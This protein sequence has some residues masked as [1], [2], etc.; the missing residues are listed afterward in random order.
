MAITTL[1]KPT[2]LESVQDDLWYIASS[3]NSGQTD[4]KFVFDV[5]NNTTGEQLVRVKLYPDPATG[6]GYFNA[7]NVVRNEIKYNWFT[8]TNTTSVDAAPFLSSISPTGNTA[9]VIYDV[10][11]GE[12]F[13]GI[14]TLNMASGQTTSY[15]FSTPLFNR[16]Q[17]NYN[18]LDDTWWTNR[19]LF[20]KCNLTQ[21]LLIPYKWTGINPATGLLIRVKPNNKVSSS[22]NIYTGITS[23]LFQLD[24]GPNTLNTYLVGAGN[25][26]DSSVSY[27]DVDIFSL[28]ASAFGQTFRVYLDCQP[29]YTPINLYFI[30][31]WGMFDTAC[32]N[33]AS[34]LSMTTER[35]SFTKKEYTFNTSAVSYFDSKNVYNESKVNYG[36]KT[37]YK[38]M[39]TM[40]YPTDEEYE[41]LSELI[42]SP[43]VYAEID[44]D[45][46]P[47]TIAD[48]NYEFSKYVN[49]QLKQ[50]EI[51][52][53]LN[54]T[55][56][57]FKR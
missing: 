10:F 49:N 43:Q 39:L 51:T 15:N 29:K 7:G 37:D 31:Q 45:Y 5:Y 22:G 20:A 6:K 54:Q 56:F 52:I 41:W 36:S 38:Y 23:S 12:D 33:L 30:N 46:Y 17:I 47:V 16:K 28:S 57:G 35:K 2:D 21:K 26:I 50:L 24:I 44:G 14:T 27:Y 13:S 25:P 18:T 9:G 48:T 11:V 32:F 8:P 40:D 4:F 3:D 19:P 53:E 55:R 42:V 34:K 1:V